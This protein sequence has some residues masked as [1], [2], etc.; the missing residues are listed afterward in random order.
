MKFIDKNRATSGCVKGFLHTRKAQ[1]P[2]EIEIELPKKCPVLG[3]SSSFEY[4]MVGKL[5]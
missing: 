2:D 5:E 4:Y 3:M 1:K